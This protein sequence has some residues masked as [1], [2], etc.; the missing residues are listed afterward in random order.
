MAFNFDEY[1]ATPGESTG[2]VGDKPVLQRPAPIQTAAPVAGSAEDIV[3]QMLQ[4]AAPVGEASSV[5]QAMAVADDE[6]MNEVV[7]R[8]DVAAHYQLLLKDSFFANPNT[9]VAKRV[10]YELRAWVRERL[11]ELVGM[12]VQKQAKLS[13]SDVEIVK[14]LSAFTPAHLHA[15]KLVADKLLAGGLNPPAPAAPSTSNQ[16][17]PRPSAPA[18]VKRTNTPGPPAPA[19]AEPLPSDAQRGRGRPFKLKE[20]EELVPAVRKHPD[21]SEEPLYNK[22][23]TPK[24]IKRQRRQ[25]AA[26]RGAIPFPTSPQQMAAATRVVAEQQANRGKDQHGQQVGGLVEIAKNMTPSEYE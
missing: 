3:R 14:A 2:E 8:L 19:V 11:A 17:P 12:N 18:L 9:R 25:V 16:P 6:Y 24:M 10:T 5:E 20:D 22:D 26:G 4:P 7:E 1:D 21:G 23:G 13:D 15:L